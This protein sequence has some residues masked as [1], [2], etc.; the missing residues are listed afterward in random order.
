MSELE[1][2]KSVVLI[3]A[4]SARANKAL[5]VFMVENTGIRLWNH[6][7]LDDVIE[8]RILES[9]K[10]TAISVLLDLKRVMRTRRQLNKS[11]NEWHTLV[12]SIR[13][14]TSSLELVTLLAHGKL[15]LS[16]K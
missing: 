8:K 11:A 12:E 1:T 15:K 2:A 9:T 6:E 4:A 10:C 13:H 7:D 5:D 3:N 16:S 14:C